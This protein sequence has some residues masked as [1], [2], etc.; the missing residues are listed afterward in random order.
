MLIVALLE[1]EGDTGPDSI[2]SHAK[3]GNWKVNCSHWENQDI[4]DWFG[5]L[6]KY[7]WRLF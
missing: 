7:L 2:V 6:G 5:R 4:P 1:C 3:D